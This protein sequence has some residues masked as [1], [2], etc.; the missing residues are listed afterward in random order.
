MVVRMWLQEIREL[1]ALIGLGC[2]HMQR[3]GSHIFIYEL[4]LRFNDIQRQQKIARVKKYIN[5]ELSNSINSMDF[6]IS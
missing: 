3:L 6:E 5:E 1:S 4:I 2:F